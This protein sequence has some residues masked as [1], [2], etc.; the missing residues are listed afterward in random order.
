MNV[1]LPAR[2]DYV[3][4]DVSPARSYD[5]GV[6]GKS[7]TFNSMVNNVKES[8]ITVTQNMIERAGQMAQSVPVAAP[9]GRYP[10]GL[11]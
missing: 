8:V 5:A 6:Y 4:T 3:R 11:L 2:P 1:G 9:A 7:V 10:N